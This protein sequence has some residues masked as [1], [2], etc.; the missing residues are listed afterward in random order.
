MLDT[1]GMIVAFVGIL[2]VGEEWGTKWSEKRLKVKA[3]YV[4]LGSAGIILMIHLLIA[5][6]FL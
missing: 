1:I 3:G 2:M 6:R 5:N 4:L